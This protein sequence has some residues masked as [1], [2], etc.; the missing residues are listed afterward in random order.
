[1]VGP[2]CC[3][4]CFDTRYL[5]RV[6]EYPWFAVLIAY[7]IGLK[8]AVNVDAESVCVNTTPGQACATMRHSNAVV[9]SST[10]ACDIPM[11]TQTKDGLRTQYI[12]KVLSVTF[13]DA[14]LAVVVGSPAVHGTIS[15]DG[16]GMVGTSAN[17]N[18]VFSQAEGCGDKSALL[19]ASINA[20]AQLV[21][22]TKSPSKD[23]AFLVES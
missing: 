2:R 18:D 13:I 19:E 4:N 20:A 3:V 23:G 16:K 11:T 14:S 22:F 21:L 12:G 9:V 8:E 1:M 6:L 17:I 5:N 10:D 15:M 7:D